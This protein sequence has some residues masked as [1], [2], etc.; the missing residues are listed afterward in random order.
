MR[1]DV[2]NRPPYLCNFIPEAAVAEL[3]GYT[4]RYTTGPS[5]H[6]VADS[7]A[8]MNDVQSILLT[9]YERSTEQEVIEKWMRNGEGN[10]RAELPRELGI[11]SMDNY[12]VRGYPF[13]AAG[14]LF[15]CGNEKSLI[16]IYV[17]K[18]P[19]RDQDHDLV[20][21]MQIAQRR[22]AEMFKCKVGALPLG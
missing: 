20:Q 22:F 12:E 1:R 15:H 21:L 14:A 4:G 6:S 18:N 9:G 5:K 16:T 3:T 8:V 19:S 2:V 11:G 7:C 10:D 13:R 17:K